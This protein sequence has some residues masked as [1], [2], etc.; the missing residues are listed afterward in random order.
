MAVGG[1]YG[2]DDLLREF[3]GDQEQGF[4]VDV[5][6]ADGKDNSNSWMLLKRPGW[7]AVLVEPE[8]SPF[9]M[10]RSGSPA[11]TPTV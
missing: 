1:Q 8:Q 7:S 3:F 4:V 10:L 11:R 2:E 6:A 5:G 9:E